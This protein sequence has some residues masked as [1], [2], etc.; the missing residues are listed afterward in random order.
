VRGRE[1]EKWKKFSKTYR[2][3]ESGRDGKVGKGRESYK[4]T[5]QIGGI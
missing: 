1:L 5:V 4:Q 2:E 3:R